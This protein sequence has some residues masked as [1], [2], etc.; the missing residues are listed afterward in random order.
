[1]F[2]RSLTPHGV[3]ADVILPS[4]TDIGVNTT[5]PPRPPS[6]YGWSRWWRRGNTAVSPASTTANSS[7]SSIPP[8]E[9]KGHGDASSDAELPTP[10][11]IGPVPPEKYYA[12]TLRLSSDQLVSLRRFQSFT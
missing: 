10:S 5:F 3:S 1:M 11:V 7:R 2:R 9:Q 4:L 6:G 8:Q 12:K